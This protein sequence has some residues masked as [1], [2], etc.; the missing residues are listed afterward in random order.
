MAE[1]TH[2][3]SDQSFPEEMKI[4]QSEIDRRKAFLE[5]RKQDAEALKALNEI[6]QKY[7]DPVI[8]A[9]YDHFLSFEETKAFFRDPGVLE[10]VKRLQK[11]YFLR[12]TQ[13]EYGAEYVANRLRIGTVHERI[14]L[15]PKWYLGAYNFYLRTVAGRLLEAF[16]KDPHKAISAFLSLMAR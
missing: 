12:L 5:F 10:R 14:K 4:T 9:L 1:T 2:S 13:G 11:E 8:E 16:G 3:G 7:A 6:G 15:E